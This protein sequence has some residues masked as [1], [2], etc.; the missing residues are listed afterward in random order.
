MI[1]G[2]YALVLPSGHFYI[3]QSGNWPYRRYRHR[4]DLENGNHFNS[5]LQTHF[6]GWEEVEI[7]EYPTATKEEAMLEEKRLIG[8]NLNHPLMCNV[9]DPSDLGGCLR[10]LQRSPETRALMSASR[11]GLS[12]APETRAKI[13]ATLASQPYSPENIAKMNEARSCKVIIDGVIYPSARAAAVACGTTVV[14]VLQRCR[15]PK[16]KYAGWQMHSPEE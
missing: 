12:P 5:K 3:G 2:A 11:T 4:R 10:G 14:T 8:I 15:N 16:S 6:T 9:Q 1:I 7:Y 13:A